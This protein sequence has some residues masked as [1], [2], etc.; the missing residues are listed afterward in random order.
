M[1]QPINGSSL[2]PSASARLPVQAERWTYRDEEVR[3]AVVGLH[4]GR[5]RYC[6]EPGGTVDHIIPRAQGGTDSVRSLTAACAS[7]NTRKGD[8]RLDGAFEAELLAEADGVANLVVAV[9]DHIRES[10][11]RA[12]KICRQPRGEGRVAVT[13]RGYVPSMKTYYAWCAAKGLSR[14][15][16]YEHLARAVTANPVAFTA[17][18]RERRCFYNRAGALLRRNPEREPVLM[19]NARIAADAKR[20][21]TDWREASCLSLRDAFDRFAEAITRGDD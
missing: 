6:G 10:R 14:G 17:S 15:G 2:Q 18:P 20:P 7:C 13:V 16:G 12:D 1:H 9:A 5:C 11:R 4:A 3:E 21:M 19:F 8:G